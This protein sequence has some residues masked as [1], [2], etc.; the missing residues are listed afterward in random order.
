MTIAPKKTLDTAP[1]PPDYYLSCTPAGGGIQPA[2]RWWNLA[3]LFSL[4]NG[5]EADPE[6]VTNLAWGRSPQGRDLLTDTNPRNAIE[7]TFRADTS[8]AA[9][10]SCLD[11]E[12]RALVEQS[13][14]EAV[15]YSLQAV[16]WNECAYQA[17]HYH[18]FLPT[19]ADILGV[20]FQ[21]THTPELGDI[22]IAPPGELHV[23]CFLFGIAR[24]RVGKAWGL[25]HRDS[26]ATALDYGARI[27]QELFMRALRRRLDIDF[28]PYHYDDCGPHYRVIGHPT[29]WHLFCGDRGAMNPALRPPIFRSN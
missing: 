23:H 25:L 12:R 20:L 2:G 22:D 28:E 17:P 26:F 9:L 10:W 21:H 14:F 8:V 16:E 4:P 6:A 5:G 24:S 18:R 29:E 13:Q 15:A 11:A 27:Y 19:P 1:S 3:E 7:I